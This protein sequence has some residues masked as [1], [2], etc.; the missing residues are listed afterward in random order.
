MTT[1][2][3]PEKRDTYRPP[4]PG[5]RSLRENPPPLDNTPPE[6]RVW[7]PPLTIGVLADTHM[8]TRARDLPVSVY[9][10]PARCRFDPARGGY[11]HAGRA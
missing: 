6:R 9:P 4:V 10:G 3:P 2:D 1:G 8:P 7:T 5:H 11:H